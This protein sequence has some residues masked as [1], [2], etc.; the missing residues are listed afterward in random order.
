MFD[1]SKFS[2]NGKT[3]IV[4]GASR[5]IGKAIAVGFAKAGAKVVVTSRKIND[6][7]ANAAEI[8]AF[9]GEAFPVQAH[10][11]KLEEIDRMVNTV[12]DKFG[13]IDIL[14]NN[15]GTSPAIG[16]V[17]D[18]DERVWETIMNLNLKG[19]YFSSQAV[20]KV[21]KNQGGGK[22]INIASIDGFKPEPGVSVYSISKAGVL[23]ITRAFAVELAPFNIQVNTIAPGPISTKLLDSHW[24]HLS[25]EEAKKQKQALAKMTPM[26]RIGEPDEIVGA[27]V[28][29]A[30]D[31][32]SYTTGA[33][34]VIDGGT[35]LF[36]LL[37]APVP[38]ED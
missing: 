3:A 24:F 25:P 2:L 13:R 14:V 32:S 20:A 18:A 26:G 31:A 19:F 4:T 37:Q 6:L 5:G 38:P 34:I 28:Y 9:G 8:K 16:T 27:V 7:E 29:L 1:L 12:M 36:A 23:M 33:E 35:L 21:M 30:S 11:G 17:L 10:L 22:I 15:A